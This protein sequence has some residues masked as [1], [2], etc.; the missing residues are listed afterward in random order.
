MYAYCGNNPVMYV[1]YSGEA[2]SLVIAGV[3][4]SAKTLITLG[5]IVAVGCVFINMIDATQQSS[6]TYPT[7]SIPK[8]SSK[9]TDLSKIASRFKIFECE[10]AA[11]AMKR[12]HKKGKIIRLVFPLAPGGYVGCDR[13]ENPISENGVHI[14]YYYNGIVYCNV[15]PEGLP[16]EQ[17]KNSFY[18]SMG[19]KGF[20]I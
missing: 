9:D 20:P 17:W 8:P 14:G 11:T 16:Y 13:F 7:I 1:D 18:D 5:A 19:R 15:Y 3:A 12:T 10:K 4:I 2:I 6:T